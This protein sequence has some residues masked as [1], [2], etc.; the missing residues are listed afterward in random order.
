MIKK[1]HHIWLGGNLPPEYKALRDEAIALNPEFEFYLW[2]EDALEGEFAE[3]FLKTTSTVKGLSKQSNVFRLL[4]LRRFGGF[5]FDLDF[6]HLQSLNNLNFS[7]CVVGESPDF[8]IQGAFIYADADHSALD[9]WLSN[10]LISDPALPIEKGMRDLEGVTILPPDMFYAMQYKDRG[11]PPHTYPHEAVAVHLWNG[12]WRNERNVLGRV[13]FRDIPCVVV[14]LES[15]KT[16]RENLS[17]PFDYSIRIQ[18]P[19]QGINAVNGRALRIIGC[20]EAHKDAVRHAMSRNYPAILVL[21]DDAVF[22]G[23][24]PDEIY[25][26][27]PVTFLGGESLPST[28]K[29]GETAYSVARTTAVIYRKDSYEKVL[30]IPPSIERLRESRIPVGGRHIDLVLSNDGVALSKRK[31]FTHSDCPSSIGHEILTKDNLYAS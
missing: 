27:H 14:S 7:G 2:D 28:R 21:E 9:S 23:D 22:I 18:N 20:M 30:S 8:G 4:V 29:E 3:E 12:Y 13:E 15:N 25:S 16:R 5:Y 11:N 1:I 31:L 19:I 6:K 24:D 17:L 10:P 26:E